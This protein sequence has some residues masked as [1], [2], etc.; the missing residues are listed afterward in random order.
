MFKNLK[1][2]NNSAMVQKSVGNNHLSQMLV[3]CYIIRKASLQERLLTRR[4][5]ICSVN[6]IYLPAF[7][8]IF[9]ALLQFPLPL[10]CLCIMENMLNCN[11]N[12]NSI[13]SIFF[14]FFFNIT[15]YSGHLF[16]ICLQY[17]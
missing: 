16:K 11:F 12:R 14:F 7:A 8:G 2:L 5:L 3:H 10:V 17:I 13:G 6:Y 15:W 1:A 9:T 4:Q